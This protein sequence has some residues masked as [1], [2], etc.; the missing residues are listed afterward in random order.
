MENEPTGGLFFRFFWSI[1]TVSDRSR[2]SI[3]VK[4]LRICRPRKDDVERW[5]DGS[6]SS[7]GKTKETFGARLYRLKLGAIYAVRY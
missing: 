1:C 4:M 2:N 6:P 3:G 7:A 5:G